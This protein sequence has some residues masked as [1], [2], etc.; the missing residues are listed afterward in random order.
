VFAF[1]TCGLSP[2]FDSP[3]QKKLQA[4]PNLVA[5]RDR[6]MEQYFPT[7]ARK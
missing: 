2:W 6:M 3:L 1:V 7:F 4:T 5:Y